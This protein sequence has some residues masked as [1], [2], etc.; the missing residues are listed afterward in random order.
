MSCCHEKRRC[1]DDATKKLKRARSLYYTFIRAAV[2]LDKTEATLHLCA[3]RM[4]ES[5]LRAS[6]SN[7]G[8]VQYSILRAMWRWDTVPYGRRPRGLW[9][10]WVGSWYEWCDKNG[11]EAHY[12]GSSRGIK[13]KRL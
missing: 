4:I 12:G 8:D 6:C 9:P 11:W 1:W 10:N 13:R 2:A 3:K 7:P 5:G